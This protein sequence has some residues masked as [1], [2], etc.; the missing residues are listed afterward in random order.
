MKEFAVER[1]P[2]SSIFDI[3]SKKG[4]DIDTI[5]QRL[6]STDTKIIRFYFTPDYAG[7]NIQVELK[8]RVTIH[9]WFVPH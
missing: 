8:L 7:Q 5:L 4:V 6:V 3:I 9:C 2:V 1:I